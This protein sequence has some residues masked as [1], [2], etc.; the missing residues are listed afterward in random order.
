MYFRR[1][2]D[3]RLD[4][5]LSQQ[6]VANLLGIKQTVYSRYERGAQTIPLKYLLILA[7]YY[8]VSID[9]IVG[10]TDRMTL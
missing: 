9:Y 5:D 10:R 7:D 3:L 4:H 1:L 8:D 2:H 6:Q